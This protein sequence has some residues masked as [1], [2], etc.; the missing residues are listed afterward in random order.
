[1]ATIM[2]F[3]VLQVVRKLKRRRRRPLPQQAGDSVATTT[4]RS[5][6]D[7]N[8]HRMPCAVQ[9]GSNPPPPPP[10]KRPRTPDTDENSQNSTTRETSFS[11]DAQPQVNE[12]EK[13]P[14]NL[15]S[16]SHQ[17]PHQQLAAAAASSAATV[18]LESRTTGSVTANGTMD[19]DRRPCSG[20][21]GD[22]AMDID[23]AN[24]ENS[25][26]NSNQKIGD[27]QNH[28][29]TKSSNSPEIYK[30]E[31]SQGSSVVFIKTIYAGE[32]S[33]TTGNNPGGN[34]ETYGER[35]RDTRKSNTDE[36]T[37]I[38]TGKQE[39]QQQEEE[40]HSMIIVGN[41]H[42]DN[43]LQ[44][45][46][47][48]FLG[49][50]DTLPTFKEESSHKTFSS[51]SPPPPTRAA[52][53]TFTGRTIYR[54][55]IAG[56]TVKSSSTGTNN[57][58][59]DAEV[60]PC[61]EGHYSMEEL[62][63]PDCTSALCTTFAP[64]GVKWLQ[65]VFAGIHDVMIVKPA[66]KESNAVIGQAILSPMK[67]KNSDQEDDDDDD[68]DE[69]KINAQHWYWIETRPH[70]KACLHAKLLLFR[71]RQGLRVA[72]CGNNL[73]Q[74]QW[75]SHRDVFWVQDFP[76]VATASGATSRQPS[77]PHNPL[78]HPTF[79]FGSKL[80]TFLND[81][82]QCADSHHQ[83][84]VQ[85]H[86]FALL[87]GIDFS[88]AKGMLIVSFPR[89][90]K[91]NK[92]QQVGGWKQLAESAHKLILARGVVGPNS[93]D[94]DDDSSDEDDDDYRHVAHTTTLYATAGSLGNLEPD[95]LLQMHKAMNGIVDFHQDKRDEPTASGGVR[96]T[97]TTTK[98][99]NGTTSWKEVEDKVRCLWPSIDTACQM[100]IWGL[101]ILRNM[102]RDHVQTIP[103]S[104]LQRIFHD[105]IPNPPIVT[106]FPGRYNTSTTADAASTT[107]T[108]STEQQQAAELEGEAI[109]ATTSAVNSTKLHVVTHGKFLY[110]D[111]G[112]L[113]VGSHNFSKAAWGLHGQQPKNVEA[114]ILLASA[115]K[116]LNQQWRSRLPCL[117]VPPRTSAPPSYK[118]YSGLGDIA[119]QHPLGSLLKQHWAQQDLIQ[120]CTD[121]NY[122]LT[123]SELV[124][125]L[126]SVSGGA[127]L[128]TSLTIP[129]L[130][131]VAEGMFGMPLNV[132]YNTDETSGAPPVASA[133]SCAK[134]KTKKKKKQKQKKEQQEII[135]IEDS[136]MF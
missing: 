99:R 20:N 86:L 98:R 136:Q 130:V 134:G 45:T 29:G 7:N 124:T 101:C 31:D 89:E 32:T 40:E 95:F 102:N 51:S 121:P 5:N 76:W 82:T 125:I 14:T 73:Y 10:G 46:K 30:H 13:I 117:L 42:T 37:I 107:D 115:Q 129:E 111:R 23:V 128:S 36:S 28:R 69:E 44:E 97:T 133:D 48:Q 78:D 24:K 93:S 122:V 18:H 12:E 91:N 80:H 26:E 103:S 65:R 59:Q 123:I 114:G 71:S 4:T 84:V 70:T 88:H 39:Q 33:T 22:H 67:R 79:Q 126:Q 85:G 35:K 1:V 3:D 43:L 62:I 8:S 27:S 58:A 6:R 119:E 41:N 63:L 105:A 56:A 25:Q 113:Y 21:A 135:T 17:H 77:Y 92:Q 74:D 94:E 47:K 57:Q 118:I 16:S 112:V 2:V 72:I 106:S 104:S 75:E 61:S 9:D 81:V 90:K 11:S 49:T 110:N 68:D 83:D 87:D 34:K 66:S 116:E 54:N 100:D 53:G 120:R 64:P 55:R 96:R 15:P 131:A 109:K 132:Q 108:R 60:E 19:L 38:N 52:F 50:T 127:T